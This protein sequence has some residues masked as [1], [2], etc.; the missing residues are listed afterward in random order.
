MDHLPRCPGALQLW[1]M[2]MTWSSWQPIV[3]RCI[4]PSVGDVWW[5]PRRG[6]GTTAACTCSPRWWCPRCAKIIII[7]IIITIITPRTI[8]I[9]LS[10]RRQPYERVHC[11]YS[12]PKSVNTRWPQTRRP[13]C[14]LDL[15]VRL[16]AAIGRTF[17]HRH[18]YYYSTMRLIL[19]YRPSEVEG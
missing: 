16:L 3:S 4:Q 7:I 10:I 19:I 11:G 1:S 17:A 8:F 15:R 6:H 9:V 12:G 18:W 5:T 13:T 14:K 2:S